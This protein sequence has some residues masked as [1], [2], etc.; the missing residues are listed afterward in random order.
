MGGN[1]GIPALELDF[2]RASVFVMEVSSY[3]IDLLKD[4]KF[5]VALLLNITPDLSTDMAILKNMRE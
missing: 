2:S 5:D 3:Q 4:A 1:I